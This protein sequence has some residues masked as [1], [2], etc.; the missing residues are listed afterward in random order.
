LLC[1]TYDALA[2][3]ILTG[4]RAILFSSLAARLALSRYG[5]DIRSVIDRES[6]EVRGDV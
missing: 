2:R 3:A 4:Q 1:R 6:S 5:S